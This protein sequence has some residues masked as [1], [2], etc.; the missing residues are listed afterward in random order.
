MI[1]LNKRPSKN[2]I[3]DTDPFSKGNLG[4]NAIGDLPCGKSVRDGSTFLR[5]YTKVSTREICD[6]YGQNYDN[7]RH[8]KKFIKQ[9]KNRYKNEGSI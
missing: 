1:K 3:P 7:I 9:L 2:I 4:Q 5:I 6:Y 8:M